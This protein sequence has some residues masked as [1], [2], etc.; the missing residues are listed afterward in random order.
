ML[1]S[2][3]RVLTL[4]M[5]RLLAEVESRAWA[6]ARPCP[7]C[8]TYSADMTDGLPHAPGCELNAL[9]DESDARSHL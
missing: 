1:P 6:D 9:L 2:A 5:G 8:R 4:R 3:N 7:I